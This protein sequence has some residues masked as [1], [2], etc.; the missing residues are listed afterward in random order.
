MLVE[1]LV[2][3]LRSLTESLRTSPV[4][5]IERIS[6]VVVDPAASEESVVEPLTTRLEV[7]ATPLTAS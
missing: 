3:A 2:R 6:S 4:A 5:V 7:D 1:M